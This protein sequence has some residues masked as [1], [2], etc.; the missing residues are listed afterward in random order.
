MHCHTIILVSQSS[1]YF[2]KKDEIRVETLYLCCLIDT[3]G[4]PWIELDS[5]SLEQ[6]IDF[7]RYLYI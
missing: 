3:V 6:V 2:G 4:R 7:F 1:T 5:D